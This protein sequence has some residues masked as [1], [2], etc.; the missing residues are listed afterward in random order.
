MIINK[1]ATVFINYAREDREVARRLY[2]ELK[3]AGA[4]PWFDEESLLPGQNWRTVIKS[5]IANNRYF[6]SL[7]SSNSVNKK[8]VVQAEMF[9]PTNSVPVLAILFPGNRDHL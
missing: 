5:A 2:N 7:L 3:A 9:R 1:E 6:I 4:E 8:G